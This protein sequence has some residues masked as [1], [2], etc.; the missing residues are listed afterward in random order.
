MKQSSSGSRV[1][2]EQLINL[3]GVGGRKSSI[4]DVLELGKGR[5]LM[6]DNTSF[7]IVEVK[8][9]SSK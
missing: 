7:G 6:Y 3:S 4:Q 2:V 8:K 9:L 1:I 5:F